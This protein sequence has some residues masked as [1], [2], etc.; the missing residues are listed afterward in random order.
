M[1]K[2]PEEWMYT[3]EG[4]E[5]LQMSSGWNL[6]GGREA[7]KLRFHAISQSPSIV[8]SRGSGFWILDSRRDFHLFFFFFFFPHDLF[9]LPLHIASLRP[10]LIP[11]AGFDRR[12]AG[13]PVP[14][15]DPRTSFHVP[16][17]GSLR[18]PLHSFAITDSFALLFRY[19]LFI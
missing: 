7:E 5:D 17:S 3:C 18:S 19:V 15:P 11:T 13:A 1:G 2:K 10:G 6:A 12:R 16:L 14:L 4:L 9:S 8:G